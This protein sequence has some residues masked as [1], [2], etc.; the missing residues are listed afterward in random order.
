MKIRNMYNSLLGTEEDI[1]AE[2]LTLLE[3]DLSDDELAEYLSFRGL[4]TPLAGLMDL[5]GIRALTSR[6]QGERA[7]E[8]HPP[9]Y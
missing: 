7:D 1:H 9:S 8:G 2:A 5:K 4:K 6:T 3:G